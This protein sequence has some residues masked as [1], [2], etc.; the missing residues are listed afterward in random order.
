MQSTSVLNI[1]G[2]L[3][4][5][6]NVQPNDVTMNVCFGGNIKWPSSI[7]AKLILNNFGEFSVDGNLNFNGG[8]TIYNCSGASMHATGS[9]NTVLTLDGTIVNCGLTTSD[10]TMNLNGS[11]NIINEC[12]FYTKGDMRI[13]PSVTNNGIFIVEGNLRLNNGQIDNQ[14]LL[15]LGSL[16]S[17][18]GADAID[19]N[20]QVFIEGSSS[21]MNGTVSLAGQ[22]WCEQSDGVD[23]NTCQLPSDCNGTADCSS[24]RLA[25][26][27]EGLDIDNNILANIC[28]VGLRL[29]PLEFIYFISEQDKG[30]VILE[31][32]TLAEKENLGFDIEISRN[33]E[34]FSSI[35][36]IQGKNQIENDYRFEISDLSNGSYL[37]RLKQ[38]NTDGSYE[39][40][41]I[42]S[43][44]LSAS[45]KIQVFPNPVV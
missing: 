6:T 2:T 8:S 14:G 43:E 38:W 36:F 26:T 28:G 32:K 27:L 11:A 34:T 15:K 24:T 41:P 39:Y 30:S 23:V 22:T 21:F 37:F 44:I 35:G 4:P 33:G 7:Q 31:W 10:G 9:T 29:L 17:I 20:G 40:S 13:D 18:S 45:N 42:T 5:N 12:S 1:A 3:E 16:T 25:N 19:G